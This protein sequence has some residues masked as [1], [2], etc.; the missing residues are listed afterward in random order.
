MNLHNDAITLYEYNA[1]FVF[2]KMDIDNINV[3]EHYV[4]VKYDNLLFE[5]NKQIE[6][7]GILF[8][9]MSDLDKVNSMQ[10]NEIIHLNFKS[11]TLYNREQAKDIMIKHIC[12]LFKER[13]QQYQKFIKYIE[14][15]NEI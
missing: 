12:S 3:T 14:V 13:I 15:K 7:D 5:L 11:K 10:S 9:H 6:P 8:C 2:F 4:Y 1:R